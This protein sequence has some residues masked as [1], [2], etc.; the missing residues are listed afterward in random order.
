[1]K[2]NI[3]AK[4]SAHKYGGE[5]EDYLFIHEFIDSSKAHVPD[6]RHRALLHNSWGPYLAQQ[7]FGSTFIN[8]AG[9]EVH[10]RDV[11]ED[12]IIQDVGRIPT[13]AECLEDLNPVN[14]GRRVKV[15][16]IHMDED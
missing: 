12:H 11:C 7:M 16:T 13:V 1:M 15:T 5:P 10:I 2:P 4:M 8:Y 6:M 3:H 9:K 14:F